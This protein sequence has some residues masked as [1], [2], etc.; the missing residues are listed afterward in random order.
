MG[1]INKNPN[2]WLEITLK[3]NSIKILPKLIF[4]SLIE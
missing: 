3:I 1:V 4:V 2:R